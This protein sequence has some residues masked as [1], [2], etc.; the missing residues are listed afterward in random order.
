MKHNKIIT[1]ITIIMEICTFYYQ[2]EN[3]VMIK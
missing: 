3:T 1:A 2:L